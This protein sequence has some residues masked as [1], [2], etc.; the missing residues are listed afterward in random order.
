MI[1]FEFPEVEMTIKRSFLSPKASKFLEK[2]YSK[3]RSF[4]HAVI[5]EVSK[6]KLII[7]YGGSF[8]FWL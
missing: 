7:G 8:R 3:P 2:R 6:A 1:F 4:A 5:V